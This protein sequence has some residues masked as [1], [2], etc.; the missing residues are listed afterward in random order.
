MQILAGEYRDICAHFDLII[1]KFMS[2]PFSFAGTIPEVN[3]ISAIFAKEGFDYLCE[4]RNIFRS[5]INQISQ[6]H[7]PRS[8]I[9]IELSAR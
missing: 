4:A 8:R 9:K 2:G 7:I 1:N 5:K 6:I 3:F